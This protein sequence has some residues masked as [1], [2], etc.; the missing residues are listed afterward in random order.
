LALT[1]HFLATVVVA[2]GSPQRQLWENSPTHTLAANA[3]KAGLIR[4]H[5]YRGW[6]F[7]DTQNHPLTAELHQMLQAQS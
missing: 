7:S 5:R 6:Y 2:A 1:L 3:V 4:C